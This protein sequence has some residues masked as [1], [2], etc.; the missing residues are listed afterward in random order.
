VLIVPDRCSSVI[1]IC[2]KSVSI[3]GAS[4]VNC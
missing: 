2:P 3:P 1:S 4:T